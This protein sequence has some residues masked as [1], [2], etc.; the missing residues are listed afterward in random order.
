MTKILNYIRYSNINISININPFIWG[1]DYMYEGPSDVDPNTYYFA[2]R[3]LF[4]RFSF[5]I[6]DGS[7]EI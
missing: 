5:I 3:L 7:F 1:I 6:D 4:I 2:I